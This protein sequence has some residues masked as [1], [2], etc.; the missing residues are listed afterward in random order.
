MPDNYV[1]YY[2][3]RAKEYDAIYQK[4]ERQSDLR[5]M[6]TW[7][8]LQ[9]GSGSVLEVA[10][11]TGYWTQFYALH[12]QRVLA[13]DAAIETLTIA[14]ARIPLPQV[15]FRVGD[16]YQLPSTPDPFDAAFAGFWWS[17]VPLNRQNAFLQGLHQQL[18]PGAQVVLIDNRYVEGSSTPISERDADGNTYQ[19]RTLKDGST[20]RVLK[21]FPNEA[22]LRAIAAPYATHIEVREWQYF[23][24]LSY[25]LA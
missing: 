7:L 5:A 9:I 23:W 3:A 12:C 21:N 10:C 25:R 20:H 17:H 2:A 14:K 22:Q 13:I 1:D 11:G 15:Q 24:A 19:P 16:A 18:K 8:S 6:E 4:P